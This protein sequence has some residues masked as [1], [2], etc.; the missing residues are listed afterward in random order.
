VA[1]LLP[2]ANL[3]LREKAH[4]P[5]AALREAGVPIALG[6]NLNPGTAP[7]SNAALA[8]GLGCVLFG[9]TPEEALRGVTAN[10][11]RA[12]RL[13]DGTGT[14]APGAPAE[15]VLFSCR[16]PADLAY[17]LGENQVEAVFKGGK[18]VA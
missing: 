18:R 15:L 7:S 13:N 8:F 5:L 9:L 17:R 10:A 1:V 2:T 4:P 11:A 16:A 14:L 12:L 3:F 6:T